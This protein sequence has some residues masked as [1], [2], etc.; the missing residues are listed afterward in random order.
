MKVNGCKGPA[1]SP[2]RAR[3]VLVVAFCD[4]SHMHWVET[5]LA[6]G[7]TAR[8]AT[9]GSRARTDATEYT[10]TCDDPF[11]ELA[12]LVD[13]PGA[14]AATPLEA[15]E[16]VSRR[17]ERLWASAVDPVSP[18]PR[19]IGGRPGVTRTL[20]IRDTAPAVV[21][22]AT[23]TTPHDGM[24]TISFA[25]HASD[26]AAPGQFE[27]AL[28][29][30]RFDPVPRVP[31]P[32]YLREM[33]AGLSLDVPR[34]L[35]RPQSLLYLGR[36]ETIRVRLSLPPPSARLSALVAADAGGTPPAVN[37]IQTHAHDEFTCEWCS[38]TDP[39]HAHGD[40]AVYALVH[41]A[42]GPESLWI[43]GRGPGS[44]IEATLQQI[45]ASCTC[46]VHT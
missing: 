30:L 34:H 33:S 7:A 5:I 27:H 42:S 19:T 46:R 20:T 21:R 9:A 3:G 40:T 31:A 43:V 4:F 10:Y 23:V 12:V 8:L 15:I 37:S 32:G 36:G 22:L 14:G 1:A 44:A 13:P 11:G 29:S 45:L 17:I 38:L 39:A 16:R 26:R 25:A 18:A 2:R 41:R 24:V 35:V 6:A 28:D